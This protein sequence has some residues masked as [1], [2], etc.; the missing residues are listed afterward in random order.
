MLRLPLIELL[1]RGPP[2]LCRQPALYI[3]IDITPRERQLDLVE[4][5]GLTGH[6]GCNEYIDTSEWTAAHTEMKRLIKDSL[7]SD[8]YGA[9]GVEP[10]GP[11]LG[12]QDWM[13]HW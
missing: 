6:V 7:F 11:A 8:T 5:G 10:P 12:P 1:L 3:R 4:D 9:R 13:A 2:L